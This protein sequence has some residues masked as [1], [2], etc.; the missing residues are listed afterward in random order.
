MKIT[1]KYNKLLMTAIFLLVA[2]SMQTR[3]ALYS[4]NAANDKFTYHYEVYKSAA[5]VTWSQPLD[6]TYCAVYSKDRQRSFYTYSYKANAKNRR[7]FIIPLKH[8][9]PKDFPLSATLQFF[10]S[11]FVYTDSLIIDI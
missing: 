8:F 9:E 4:R 11:D 5:I 2:V 7:T 3:P 10:G 1:N 6:S